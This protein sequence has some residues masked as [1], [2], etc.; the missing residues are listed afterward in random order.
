MTL[1]IFN[2]TDTI[3]P[4][5]VEPMFHPDGWEYYSNGQV[6][7]YPDGMGVTWFSD[8]DTAFNVILNRKRHS[9]SVARRVI[10]DRERD[11]AELER[12]RRGTTND[13]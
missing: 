12:Q 13:Q 2:G 8:R 6:Q 7:L 9:V 4:V 5:E 10:D 11:I 3:Y 1:Y